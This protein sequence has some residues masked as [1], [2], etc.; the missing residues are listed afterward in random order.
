MNVMKKMFSIS[1]DYV[2][3]L[4]GAIDEYYHLVEDMDA[5]KQDVCTSFIMGLQNYTNIIAHH[6][7]M[8]EGTWVVTGIHIDMA[9]EILYDLYKNLIHWL[10]DKVKVGQ[11]AAEARKDEKAWRE[12]FKRCEVFD[13]DGKGRGWVKKKAL[14]TIFGQIQN[15]SSMTSVNDRYN[16]ILQMFDQTRQGRMVYTRMKDSAKEE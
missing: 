8:M 9:K 7:A 15:L 12:A 1:P 16:R 6:M 5:K 14:M 11:T 2:P 10:E 3:A 13:I 4:K